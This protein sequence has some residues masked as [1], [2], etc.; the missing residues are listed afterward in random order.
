M[1]GR[2]KEHSAQ[3][4]Y[5]V[6]NETVQ[7]EL[8]FGSKEKTRLNIDSFRGYIEKFSLFSNRSEALGTIDNYE[9]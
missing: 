5:D 8:H 4:L 3:G 1:R 9:K 2:G 7:L 6:K